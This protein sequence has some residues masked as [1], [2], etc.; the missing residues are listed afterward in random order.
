EDRPR[1]HDLRKTAAVPDRDP[2]ELDRPPARP[3]HL[4]AAPGARQA[5]RPLRLHALLRMLHVLAQ[6]LGALHGAEQELGDADGD[7]AGLGTNREGE[8]GLAAPTKPRNP[9]Y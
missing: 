8:G 9:Y 6:P 2:P 4:R 1:R 7:C 3:L 5:P